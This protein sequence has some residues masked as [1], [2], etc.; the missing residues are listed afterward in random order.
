MKSGGVCHPNEYHNRE[1]EFSWGLVAKKHWFLSF[2]YILTIIGLIVALVTGSS[3]IKI[4]IGSL[5]SL[6]I[7][8]AIT[9]WIF[10]FAYRTERDG[11]DTY[12]STLIRNATPGVRTAPF[13]S[14]NPTN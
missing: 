11:L 14:V 7:N 1:G 8:M 4:T 9:Y 5:I 2:V 10:G 13:K 3:G 6:F 12:Q